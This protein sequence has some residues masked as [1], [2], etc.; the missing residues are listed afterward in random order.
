MAH[1][2]FDQ[3]Q[4][5]GSASLVTATIP[6]AFTDVNW[7]REP[8]K[9]AIQNNLKL[10][11]SA[12]LYHMCVLLPLS[13][14]NSW[15]G[16]VQECEWKHFSPWWMVV[17]EFCQKTHFSLSTFFSLPLSCSLSLSLVLPLSQAMGFQSLCSFPAQP[18]ASVPPARARE[19]PT[20][21]GFMSAAHEKPVWPALFQIKLTQMHFPSA[22][23]KL[24]KLFPIRTHYGQMI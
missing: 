12:R 2:M 20:Q 15:N 8:S 13:Q 3:T 7:G 4:V 11:D 17:L 24:V 19:D 10:Y 9:C 18:L 23:H 5:S 14:R 22:L 21:G 6:P 1:K 16:E